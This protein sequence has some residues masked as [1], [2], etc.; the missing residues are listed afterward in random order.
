[1]NPY[2][3]EVCLL[4]YVHTHVLLYYMMSVLPM[5]DR[6]GHGRVTDLRPVPVLL[7]TPGAHGLDSYRYIHVLPQS[8]LAYL[9]NPMMSHF[10]YQY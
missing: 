1:M 6:A 9:F 4:T 8:L 10:L 7:H 2:T 3:Y 5:T